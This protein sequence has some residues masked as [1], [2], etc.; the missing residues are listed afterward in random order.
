LSIVAGP[1]GQ[2]SRASGALA[3]VIVSTV[4]VVMLGVVAVELF[5]RLVANRPVDRAAVDAVMRWLAMAL[6]AGVVLGLPRALLESLVP[7][8]DTAP[9]LRSHLSLR[10]GLPVALI[11]GLGAVIGLAALTPGGLGPLGAATFRP[12][13]DGS[14]LGPLAILFSAAV[15]GGAKPPESAAAIAAPA[16]ILVAAGHLAGRSISLAFLGA[17]VPYAVAALVALLALATAPWRKAIWWVV[18]CLVML[19]PGPM[20]APG[21]FTP[22]E[23]LAVIALAA[24]PV[25]LI[26][27]IAV[28]RAPVWRMFR[29]ATVEIVSF[30]VVV[31]AG[32]A[33]S[34]LLARV[35]V[36]E[37]VGAGT[38]RIGPPWLTLAVVAAGFA[39]LSLLMT[40]LLALAAVWPLAAGI[41]Q[42]SGVDPNA[43]LVTVALAGHLALAIRAVRPDATGTGPT[44]ATGGWTVM[45]GPNEG[46]PLVFALLAALALV[47]AVPASVT[48]LTGPVG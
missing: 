26:L 15:L 45:M 18:G 1:I 34:L 3:T 31:S 33:V 40:P 27:H 16:L 41:V 14:F 46:W 38:T 29:T 17:V 24:T 6:A 25:A 32:A 10:P 13:A 47:I 2:L 39:V 11:L 36:A 19:P 44:R 37:F 4:V 35:G 48:L 8:G 20:L 21:L 23:L 12:L 30:V 22:G 5:A 7:D 42:R 43:A 9:S 28:G